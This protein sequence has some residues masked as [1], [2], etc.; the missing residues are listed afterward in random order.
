MFQSLTKKKS[1]K[2][3]VPEKVQ[4]DIFF[5]HINPHWSNIRF[6]FCCFSWEPQNSSINL[7]WKQNKIKYCKHIYKM[8]KIVNRNG[9]QED[10]LISIWIYSVTIAFKSFPLGFSLKEIT[11]P[12]LSI[13]INPKSEAR[14]S[15]KE[16][17]ITSVE[18]LENKNNFLIAFVI[19]LQF[20]FSSIYIYY[21]LLPLLGCRNYKDTNLG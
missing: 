12:L 15:S 11:L 9:K 5:E 13:F 17:V 16:S 1:A 2:N 18:N 7:L 3:D 14:L 4:Q 8:I 19:F 21:S 6:L 10:R 20:Q